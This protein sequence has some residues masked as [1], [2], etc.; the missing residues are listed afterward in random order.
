[1]SQQVSAA[2]ANV[3]VA[4]SSL[5]RTRNIY[6]WIFLVPT[7]LVV[8]VVAIYPLAQTFY[9]SFTD[10]RFGQSQVN[11]VGLDNYVRLTTQDTFFADSVKITVAFTVITVVIETILGMIVALVVNSNFKGRGVMRAVM[12]IPWAV[13]TVVSTKLWAWMYNDQFG[14]F[15]DILH[16][17]GIVKGNFAFLATSNGTPFALG[18]ISAIDIWKTTPFMALLLLAG[19]QL[20]PTDMYEAARVDGANR[21]QQFFRLTLPLLRPALLVALILRTL[22]A[23]RAFDVFYVLFGNRPDTQSMSVYAQQRLVGGG[24][25]GYGSALCVAIFLIILIFV[26]IYVTLFRVEEA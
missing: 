20:I 4:R 11:F 12:L 19:L 7:L 25:E 21:I 5:N 24:R 10:S 8:A 14:V 9:L 15:T 13:P 17:L 26:I 22:D 16:R 18:I 6:A 1:M 23:L 2:P 3:R